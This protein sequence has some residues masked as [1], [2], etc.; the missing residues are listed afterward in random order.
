MEAAI[1]NL[2]HIKKIHSNF[3]ESQI[4]KYGRGKKKKFKVNLTKKL[5]KRQ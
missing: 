2:S 5:V 3:I 1:N 4:A